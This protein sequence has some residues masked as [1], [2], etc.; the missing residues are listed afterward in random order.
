MAPSVLGAGLLHSHSTGGCSFLGDRFFCNPGCD[1][2][3]YP[4]DSPEAGTVGDPALDTAAVLRLFGCL[5]VGA[6]FYTA[7]LAALLLQLSL[8]NGDVARACTFRRA[9]G[10]VDGRTVE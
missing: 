5:R 7:A 3:A 6:N 1:W 2:W 9:R 4:F 10:A 8:W